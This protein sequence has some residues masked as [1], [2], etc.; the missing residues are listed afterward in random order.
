MKVRKR[1]VV[2][3][4]MLAAAFSSAA[5]ANRYQTVAATFTCKTATCINN[6]SCEGTHYVADGC[7]ITCY[8]EQGAPGQLV[9]S[10]GASCGTSAPM[11][12]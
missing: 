12:D 8:R 11:N 10:G 5:V 9:Y 7:N 2:F 4:L 6:S 1:F 3:L